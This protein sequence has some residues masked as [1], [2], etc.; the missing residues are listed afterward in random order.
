MKD[1]NTESIDFKSFCFHHWGVG[2]SLAAIASLILGLLV[3][4]VIGDLSAI[5]KC[6]HG[7]R[8]NG[9]I[10]HC[11]KMQNPLSGPT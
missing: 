1:L 9:A 7:L 5:Y 8:N 4:C 11:R 3:L 6:L 2:T 10:L